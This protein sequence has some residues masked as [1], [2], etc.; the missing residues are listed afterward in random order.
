[1]SKFIVSS[2]VIILI[3]FTCSAHVCSCATDRDKISYVSAE[4]WTLVQTIQPPGFL[5]SQQVEDSSRSEGIDP[6][7]ANQTRSAGVKSPYKA[8]LYALV[9]GFA[10]HG[11]GHIYTD[12]KKTGRILLATEMIRLFMI[13]MATSDPAYDL[14]DTT[15]NGDRENDDGSRDWL[16]GTGAFLFLGS[17]IYD[18]V[19]APLAVKRQ[20]RK[21]LTSENASLKIH[22][23]RTRML[24]TLRVV[25]RF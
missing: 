15:S 24:L 14:E 21:L 7:F 18:M 10:F 9:P 2:M 1:M 23:D 25:N 11:S 5:L 16:V 17:W 20:N 3:F 12:E 6:T 4:H 22:L 8:I 19:G 13:A